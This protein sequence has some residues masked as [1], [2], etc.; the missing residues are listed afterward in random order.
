MEYAVV[1]TVFNCAKFILDTLASAINLQPSPSEIIVIDDASTDNSYEIVQNRLSGMEK[2]RIILNKKNFGQSYGR[3][4]G[5][6]LANSKY[7]IFVDGDDLSFPGRA[8]IH[9]NRLTQGAD[10]SYVSS[11]KTYANNYT[12]KYV[13]DNFTSTKEDSSMLIR[14]VLIGSKSSLKLSLYS[15]CATLAVNRASFLSIGGFDESFRRLEDID[16]FCRC[17]A[18]NLTI[19]WDSHI[20]V[21]RLN[22]N[23]EDK[24]GKINFEFELKILLKNRSFLTTTE[25]FLSKK[26][27]KFKMYYFEKNY[28]QLFL[29][30]HLLLFLLILAPEKLFSIRDRL[31]HDLKQRK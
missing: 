2:S 31:I 12:V 7:V 19:N 17:V 3:N 23:R 15:P 10:L 22:S 4:L 27:L 16:F 1:I 30:F 25:F 13:N 8:E 21:E 29:R 6:R 20:G 24:S 14:Q 28:F 11:L 9:L 5:V 18:K 26:I